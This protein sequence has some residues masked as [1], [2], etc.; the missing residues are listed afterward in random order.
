MSTTLPKPGDLVHLDFRRSPN[1][2]ARSQSIKLLQWNIER[3]Y[4]LPKIIKELQAIDADIIALQEID[5][6]CERS[7]SIDTGKE[8]AEQLGLNYI[9]FCEFEELHSPVRSPELQGGGVHGNG[10]LTKFDVSDARLVHHSMHPVDWNDPKQP[11]AQT[12]PRRGQRAALA[13]TVHTPQGPLLCY[14]LHLEVF[15]GMLA[16]IEQFAD[17]L[18]DSKIQMKKGLYHQAIL[19]DLNTMAHGIARLSP[20][21]CK[22][23]M[24]FWSIGQSEAAFW[25]QAVFQVMDP[26]TV[27]EQD[28]NWQQRAQAGMPSGESQ[29]EQQLETS[30]HSSQANAEVGHFPPGLL[31][32]SV[33]DQLQKL[34]LPPHVCQDIT[35]PGFEDP[36]DPVTTVTL[37]NPAYKYFGY[38]LMKGKLDWLLLRKMKVL[39]KDIGNHDYSASD[40]KWLCANVE[41]C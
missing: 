40:H 14:C 5:I 3:G 2:P 33:N 8:I 12:E 7:S 39:E 28:S 20:K 37:D 18:Q 36:F 32:V 16:R 35:N 22:D 24:R 27:P 9:F 6:G 25:D 13:A 34:G 21:F 1:A 41:L 29:P 4:K 31:G 26:D 19:G 17:V 23:K 30:Q 15:C 38:S 11:L 10:I